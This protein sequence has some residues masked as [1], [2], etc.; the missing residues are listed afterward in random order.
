MNLVADSLAVIGRSVIATC[1]VTGSLA[2]FALSGRAAALVTVR[3][4]RL[5]EKGKTAASME[6]LL[7]SVAAASAAVVT[8]VSILTTG[9]TF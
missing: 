2:L 8:K 3:G 7:H 4:K 6:A 9:V 1:Q 5:V